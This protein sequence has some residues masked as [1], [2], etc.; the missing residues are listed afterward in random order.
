VSKQYK[1]RRNKT[2]RLRKTGQGTIDPDAIFLHVGDTKT[3]TA[4]VSK[5]ESS[6]T[7]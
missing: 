7:H 6:F 3:S 4:V 2:K 5:N 1:D